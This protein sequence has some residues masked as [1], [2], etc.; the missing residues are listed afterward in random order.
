LLTGVVRLPGSNG[1]APLSDISCEGQPALFL[2]VPSLFVI[3]YFCK[4]VGEFIMVEVKAQ[5]ELSKKDYVYER[6]F[7][8]TKICVYFDALELVQR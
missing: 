7:F 6:M 3:E 5:L 1:Q 8:N 4:A 2:S